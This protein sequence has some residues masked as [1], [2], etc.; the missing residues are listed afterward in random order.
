MW[1][2]KIFE[3]NKNRKIMAKISITR[4]LS[5]LN[6]LKDRYEKEVDGSKLIGVQVGAKMTAPYL[7]YKPEDFEKQATEKYQSIKD[8]SKRI[9]DIKTKIDISNFSTKV[10]VGGIEMTVLEAIRMKDQVSLKEDLLA[11]LKQQL[12]KQRALLETSELEN[13][14]RIEKIVADQTSAG[15]KDPDIE[16]KAKESIESLYKVSF[17]DPIKLEEEIEKLDKEISDFKTEVD[18]VLSESNST[19]FIEA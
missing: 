6:T 17:V 9:I 12:R 8:L 10:T 13:K 2:N 1:N 4:A 16:K 11:N 18:Y 15:S 5:E 3:T 7:Q 14:N 19:T